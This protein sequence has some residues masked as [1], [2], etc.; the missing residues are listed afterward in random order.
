MLKHNTWEQLR[1]Q[2]ITQLIARQFAGMDY[3]TC[4]ALIPTCV[5]QFGSKQ[6]RSLLRTL[7]TGAL[8]TAQGAHRCGLRA[9]PVCPY[10]QAE[11]EMEAH[12]LWRCAAWRHIHDPLM[13]TVRRLAADLQDLPAEPNW[14]PCLK[15]CGLAR[16]LEIFPAPLKEA[17]LLFL[18]SLHMAYVAILTARK[19]R[20]Q[21]YP[22]LFTGCTHSNRLNVYPH[23]QLVGT[24]PPPTKQTVLTLATPTCK[25]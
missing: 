14:R 20:D 2:C 21:K 6:E 17:S 16:P 1:L 11:A 12:I 23:H 18:I 24:L 15:L 25:S 22:A 10:C 5:Q 9:S 8:W 4:K 19:L 3:T 13:T 7:L